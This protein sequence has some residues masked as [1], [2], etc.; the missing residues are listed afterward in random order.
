[1]KTANNSP[2]IVA[3]NREPNPVEANVPFNATIFVISVPPV[4]VTNAT[5]IKAPKNIVIYF[6][7]SIVITFV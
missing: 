3:L 7:G 2:K 4:A 5:K 1:M 6:F